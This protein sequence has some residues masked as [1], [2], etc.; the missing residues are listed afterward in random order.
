[1]STKRDITT[2]VKSATMSGK[3]TVKK[4]LNPRHEAWAKSS[5]EN[6]GLLMAKAEREAG[7]DHVLFSMGAFL[8]SSEFVESVRQLKEGADIGINAMLSG[9]VGDKQGD[10]TYWIR[11]FAALLF[12]AGEL[13]QMRA[14][15]RVAGA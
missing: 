11:E 2:H 9:K 10:D 7:D 5:P 13:S 6:I 1:M 14:A 3:K 8:H 15:S 12:R 4:K